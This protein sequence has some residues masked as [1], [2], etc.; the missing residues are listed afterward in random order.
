MRRA[1][2]IYCVDNMKSTFLP[3]VIDIGPK[4]NVVIAKKTLGV[5][6]IRTQCGRTMPHVLV[7]QEAQSMQKVTSFY[8]DKSR[9][10]FISNIFADTAV[11]PSA[12]DATARREQRGDAD[13]A[14]GT[15][16][17]RDQIAGIKRTGKRGNKFH[18]GGKSRT[19]VYGTRNK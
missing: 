14:A 3:N 1:T 15:L 7:T 19:T 8:I 9:T 6:F 16:K 13:A 2:G 12:S 5:E 17:T 11:S 18:R 4:F 10:F